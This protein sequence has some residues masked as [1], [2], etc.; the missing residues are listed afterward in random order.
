MPTYAFYFRC[1]ILFPFPLLAIEALLH[2]S[3]LFSL[4]NTFCIPAPSYRSNITPFSFTF[5]FLRSLRASSSA[6]PATFSFFVTAISSP[7][8][9]ARY[10]FSYY[11]NVKYFSNPISS[12][13]TIYTQR[14]TITIFRLPCIIVLLHEYVLITIHFTACNVITKKGTKRLLLPCHAVPV[15]CSVNMPG[16]PSPTLFMPL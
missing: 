2:R 11:G 13:T 16:S 14:I 3:L 6:H 8:T 5:S 10:H 9:H 7:T 1:K 4:Q 12:T 15:P